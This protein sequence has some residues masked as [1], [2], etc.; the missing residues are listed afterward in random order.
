[1]TDGRTAGSWTVVNSRTPREAE[2]AAGLDQLAVDV[3]EGAGDRRVDREEGADGDERD[4][5]PLADLEPQDEERDP[6]QRRDRADRAEGRAEERGP[7][8][9]RAR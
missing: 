2:R 5:G 3:A 6:G 8:S 9:G 7:T 1:M 4:L